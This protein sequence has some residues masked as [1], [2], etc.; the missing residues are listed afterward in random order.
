MIREFLTITAILLCFQALQYFFPREKFS[1]N[2]KEIGRDI[3]WFFINEL[4]MT[5]IIIKITFYSSSYFNQIFSKVI[6]VIDFSSYNF[7]P[8]LIAFVLVLDFINYWSHRIL[9]TTKLW[10][11]HKLHHSVET[12]SPFSSFRHSLCEHI[13]HMLILVCLTSFISISPEVRNYGIMIFT[14][15]CVLQHT[16]IKLKLPNVIKKIFI[17]P[18]CHLTH[19]SKVNYIEKGQNFGFILSIWDRLFKSYKTI[20]YKDIELG[21]ENSPFK[22]NMSKEFVYPLVK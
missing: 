20:D 5:F 11:F 16:N 10:E 6:N 2:F 22:G 12:L 15:V 13:Y 4:L 1:S 3:S 19:H 9:H 14:Y 21:L 18:D 8:Q 17:T 7:W